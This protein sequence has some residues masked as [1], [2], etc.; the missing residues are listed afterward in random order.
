VE[1]IWARRKVGY[2]LDQIRANGEKPELKNEVIALAKK[3]GITTP[4]TSWLIVPDGPTPVVTHGR[5]PQPKPGEPQV[6]A[7][8]FNGGAGGVPAAGLLPKDGKSDKTKSVASYAQDVNGAPGGQTAGRGGFEGSK[9]AKVPME[10]PADDAETKSLQQTR[11]KLDAYRQAKDALA[12]R[13]QNEVQAGKLGVDLAVQMNNLRNQSQMEFTAL[14]QVSGRNCLEVGGVWID[15]GFTP[16]TSYVTVKAQSDAYFRILEL[17]PKVK[18][19]FRLGNYLVW[20]TPSGTA[21]IVDAGEGKEKLSDEEINKL[22][23]AKK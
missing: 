19:V 11:E 9:Y 10:T 23:V 2:L 7:G 20:M 6:G 16:K 14:R 1:E 15:E 21:L 22:F 17:Q 5:K 13:K 4:Y 3:Y 18:D 8:G 12:K